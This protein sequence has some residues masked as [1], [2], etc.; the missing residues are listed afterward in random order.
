M[1]KTWEN[2]YL[3]RTILFGNNFLKGKAFQF[4]LYRLK[5]KYE[6][7]LIHIDGLNIEDCRIQPTFYFCDSLMSETNDPRNRKKR[8]QVNEILHETSE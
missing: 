8:T 3:K 1:A 5:Y 7:S 2:V 6:G 4:S